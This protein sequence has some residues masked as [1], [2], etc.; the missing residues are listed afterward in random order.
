M[1][2]AVRRARGVSAALAVVVL[3]LVAQGAKAADEGSV[4]DEPSLM[5]VFL[6]YLDHIISIP[7]G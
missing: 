3:L 1:R 7:P 2:G 6:S 5:D 4:V